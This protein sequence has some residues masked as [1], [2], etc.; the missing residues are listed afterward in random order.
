[1]YMR[2]FLWI[3]SN[4]NSMISMDRIS[5]CVFV[6]LEIIVKYGKQKKF[7]QNN[8]YRFDGCGVTS[9]RKKRRTGSR[10]CF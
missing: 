10:T 4:F 1:M 3:L 5:V 8:G 7:Y 2:L 9:F 6:V